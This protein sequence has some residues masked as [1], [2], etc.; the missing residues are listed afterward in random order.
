MN[1]KAQDPTANRRY[2]EKVRDTLLGAAQMDNL[3]G[4]AVKSTAERPGSTR[5]TSRCI[6][7][8]A[9]DQCGCEG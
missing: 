6:F 1:K 5:F 8:A 2:R 7:D 3:A 4:P 9:G